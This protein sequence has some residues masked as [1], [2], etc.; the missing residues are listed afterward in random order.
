[1]TPTSG[2]Q[3]GGE[4]GDRAEHAPAAEFDAREQER[5]RDADRGGEDRPGDRDDER[6]AS[7]SRSPGLATNSRQ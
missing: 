3:R 1:M 6:G 5:E 2:G 4:R 7:A